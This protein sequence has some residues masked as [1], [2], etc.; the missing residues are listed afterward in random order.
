M[1]GIWFVSIE[2]STSYVVMKTGHTMGLAFDVNVQDHNC[3]MKFILINSEDSHTSSKH[4][5]KSSTVDQQL[6]CLNYS[7][8]HDFT[9]RF[10]LLY[11]VVY[12]M[13]YS[14]SCSIRIYRTFVFSLG[15]ISWSTFWK[16]GIKISGNF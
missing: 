1:L 3:F 16:Y 14:T 9:M 2:Y 10:Y 11:V 7:N 4:H 8:K 5:A 15:W 6:Q 12:H 13:L